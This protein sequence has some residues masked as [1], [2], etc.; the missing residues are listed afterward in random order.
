MQGAAA[1]VQNIERFDVFGMERIDKHIV[2]AEIWPDRLSW[3]TAK[4]HRALKIVSIF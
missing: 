2:D 3:K 4:V 1:K